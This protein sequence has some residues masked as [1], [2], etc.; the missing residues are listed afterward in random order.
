MARDLAMVSGF[1]TGFTMSVPF[2]IA[3]EIGAQPVACAPYTENFECS[4]MPH[5]TNSPYAL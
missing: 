3:C 2:F 4:T 1:G 5:F